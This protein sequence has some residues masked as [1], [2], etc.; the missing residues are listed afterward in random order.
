[1]NMPHETSEIQSLLPSLPFTHQ[2]GI[3]KTIEWLQKAKS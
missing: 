1:M 2:E 3:K